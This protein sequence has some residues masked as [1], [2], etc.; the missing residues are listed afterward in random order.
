MSTE[1]FTMSDLLNQQ[2]EKRK[3][4]AAGVFDAWQPVKEKEDQLLADHGGK[5]ENA[6]KEIQ[7]QVNQNREKFYKDWG[8][9]GKLAADLSENQQKQREYLVS[10]QRLIDEMKEDMERKRERTRGRH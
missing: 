1:K 5:Y 4:L 9:Q 6:P 3:E 2:E 7:E 8:S 10:K